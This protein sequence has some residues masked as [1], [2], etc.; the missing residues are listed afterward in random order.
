MLFNDRVRLAGIITAVMTVLIVIGV[1]RV[2]EDKRLLLT[3]VLVLVMAVLQ[4]TILLYGGPQRSALAAA[5]YQYR[6][7][8]FEAA[9]HLL[10]ASFEHESA[11]T[12]EALALLGNT[13]RQMGRLE[14]SEARLR[15]A[16][17]R[18]EKNAMALYGLGLTRLANGH[19]SEAA[20]LIHTALEQGMRPAVVADLALALHLANQDEERTLEALQRAG[21]MLALEDY[22]ALMVNYLL[23]NLRED[24]HPGQNEPSV[25][26]FRMQKSASGLAYW[27]SQARR[28]A[29]TD[30]GRRMATE[31]L[32]IKALL[33]GEQ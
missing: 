4:M 15:E 31:V 1:N 11:R 7:G 17:E 21:T 8:N 20:D 13:Y 6:H 25:A 28:F 14:L 5:Q 18:D 30:Y 24:E 12:V 29:D 33:N 2:E 9:A 10:E 22:R 19:Y 23:Y 26:H 3:V 32:A 16:L 27:Q